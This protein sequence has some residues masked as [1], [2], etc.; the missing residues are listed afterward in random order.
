MARDLGIAAGEELDQVQ[1]QD[2]AQEIKEENK[3]K[4]KRSTIKTLFKGES[5][6]T[7]N[8]SSKPQ[9]VEPGPLEKKTK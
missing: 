3:V 1:E 9:R 7:S 2:E 8:A 5:F 6:D 4:G